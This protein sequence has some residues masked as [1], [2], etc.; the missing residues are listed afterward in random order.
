MPG[1]YAFRDFLKCEETLPS[2][3]VCG[4]LSREAAEWKG[5]V[6]CRECWHRAVLEEDGESEVLL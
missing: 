3:R 4:R 5:R 2:G 6:L 1:I